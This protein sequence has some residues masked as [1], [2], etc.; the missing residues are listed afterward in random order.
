MLRCFKRGQVFTLPQILGVI[1]TLV[2][3]HIKQLAKL[4]GSIEPFVSSSD[5]LERCFRW[6]PTSA[7]VFVT[8]IIFDIGNRCMHSSLAAMNLSPDFLF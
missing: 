5:H 8:S 7:Q 6:P 1:F 2:L 4:L 3:S